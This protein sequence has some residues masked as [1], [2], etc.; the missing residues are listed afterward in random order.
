MLYEWAFEKENAGRVL[1]KKCCSG[2]GRQRKKKL[3][4][5]DLIVLRRTVHS[6]FHGNEMPTVAK[7]MRHFEKDGELPSMSA[8]TMHRT[9]KCA[10]KCAMFV[11]MLGNC[12]ILLCL[13]LFVYVATWR[14]VKNKPD[15][16]IKTHADDSALFVLCWLSVDRGKKSVAASR[17]LFDCKG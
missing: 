6:F 16:T 13:F 15:G 17:Y 5:F 4:N 14:C 11:W 7:L 3:R 2:K 9:L 8:A 12:R 1:A 10:K